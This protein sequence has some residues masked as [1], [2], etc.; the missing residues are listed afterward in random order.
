MQGRDDDYVA[1]SVLNTQIE[2]SHPGGRPKLRWMDRLKDDMKQNKTLPRKQR[3]GEKNKDIIL[4]QR[5]IVTKP[6]VAQS[7][8]FDHVS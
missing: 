4:H 2:G 1:K 5:L 6:T 8:C 3:K 7:L